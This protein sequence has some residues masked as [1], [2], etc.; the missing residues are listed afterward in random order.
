MLLF[1]HCC[2]ICCCIIC[3]L[4]IAVSYVCPL[5]SVICY[6]WS[7]AQC[8]LLLLA[9][10]S[11]S[12]CYCWSTAAVCAFCY[13]MPTSCLWT[14][15]CYLRC[16]CLWTPCCHDALPHVSR[17]VGFPGVT[18]SRLVSCKVFEVM[19]VLRTVVM[20]I[21]IIKKKIIKKKK[22]KKIIVVGAIQ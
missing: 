7:A 10:C 9:H 13:A 1:A 5:R 11:V 21:I 16:C 20:M 19:S 17:F 2:V 14:S 3:C 6:C 22:K 4:L 12:V 8:L 18:G 15:W